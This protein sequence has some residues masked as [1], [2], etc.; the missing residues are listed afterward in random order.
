M[1]TKLN[2]EG[3]CY[4]ITKRTSFCPQPLPECQILQVFEFAYK[5]T[6]GK[7]GAHRSYRSGGQLQRKNGEL[8][9]NT[10]QGKL[11]EFAVFSEL[12][13][14]G[15]QL[16]PPDL[17]T[18][19]LGRWDDTDLLISDKKISIK[20]AAFFSNLLLLEVKDWDDNGVYLPN[21]TIYDKTI[22][23][24]IKPDIKKIFRQTR[25]FYSNDIALE[26]LKQTVLNQHYEFDIP[27]YITYQDLK[28]LI[29]NRY[30]LP[31][32]SLL[33]GK[34]KM[35]ACNYYLQSAELRP[36]AN[37]RSLLAFL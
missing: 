8:F 33:N 28:H 9:C 35:D 26:I 18:W 5:M 4:H 21:N 7:E 17:E 2:Q 12:Q 23:V 29:M 11:A 25:L 27:G 36:F 22:L 30:I 20:S 16:P 19:A 14:M 3:T 31:Q 10:F 15:F 24:R 6:F 37:L 34:T 32:N 1:F 13:R